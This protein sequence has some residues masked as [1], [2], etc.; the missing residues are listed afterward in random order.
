MMLSL[1]GYCTPNLHLGFYGDPF[2][3][4]SGG[5]GDVVFNGVWKWTIPIIGWLG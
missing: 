2:Y 5:L 3:G 1:A 4:R